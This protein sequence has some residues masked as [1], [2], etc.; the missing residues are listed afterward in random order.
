[1]VNIPCLPPPQLESDIDCREPSPIY[2]YRRVSLGDVGYIR[3]GRFHL[4]FSAGIPLGERELGTDV[5]LTFEP[6]DTGPILRRI[7]P[8][9]HLHTSASRR[10]GADVGSSVA[11]A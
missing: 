1:V 8:K 11:V 3:E 7:R 5:P 2:S 6:L 9:G 10:I 4:L